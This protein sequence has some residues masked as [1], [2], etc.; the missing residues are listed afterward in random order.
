MQGTGKTSLVSKFASILGYEVE[1]VT[2][3]QVHNV[4]YLY[5]MEV[6]S[7]SVMLTCAWCAYTKWQMLLK[8]SVCRI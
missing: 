6:S 7:E 5:S 3:Y 2:L 4:M 8:F 1:P